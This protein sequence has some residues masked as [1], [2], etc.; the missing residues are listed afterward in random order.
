MVFTFLRLAFFGGYHEVG[1]IQFLGKFAAFLLVF[2][3]AGCSN[4]GSGTKLFTKESSE[5]PVHLQ[6]KE[7][8]VE[9]GLAGGVVQ[10]IKIA[11]DEADLKKAVHRYRLSQSITT[12][13]TKTIGADLNGDG[14]GEALVLL[15]GEGWC[16]STGCPL[17]VFVKGVNGFRKMSV[18]KRVKLPIAVDGQTSEGWR[19]LIVKSGNASIGERF[20]RLKFVNNYPAN[21]TMVKEKLTALPA[22]S[23]ALL[24]GEMQPVNSGL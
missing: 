7:K 15:E 2:V 9:T 19:D 16:I 14:V 23:E 22:G 20:V 18:I 11:I 1:M 10:S 6:G 5:G 12:G 24:S 4:N 13:R 3:L 21:A 17:L 8:P